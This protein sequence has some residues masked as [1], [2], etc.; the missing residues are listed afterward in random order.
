MVLVALGLFLVPLLL[1]IPS[2]A[3]KQGEVGVWRRAGLEGLPVTHLALGRGGE[4]PIFYA[5]VRHRGMY[6]S[7]DEGRTWQTANMDLPRG[8]WGQWAVT[9]LAVD[10]REARRVYVAL[11]GGHLFRSVNGGSRW[12]ALAAPPGLEDISLLKVLPQG[13]GLRWY[14]GGQGRLW[15]TD[16]EGNTWVSLG[17]WA[18]EAHL[19]DL[20]FLSPSGQDLC[21]AAGPEGVWCSADGGRSWSRQA[22]GLGRSAVWHLARAGDG[23]WY[24]GTHNGVYRSAD[25]GTFWQP[26]RVGLPGGIVQALCADPSRPATLYAG[27]AHGGV[28]RTEDGLHWEP[29]GLGLGSRDVFALHLDPADGNLLYAGTEDGLWAVR[30]GPPRAMATTTPTATPR[31]PT[32]TASPASTPSATPSA[33]PTPRPTATPTPTRGPTSTPTAT[34]SPTDTATATSTPTP[35]VA[36]PT[37]TA[38]ATATVQEPPT[39]TP[40]PRPPT[41]TPAPPTPTR[42]PTP[43]PK[44]PPTPTPPR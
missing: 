5:A 29:L 25:R 9:A 44:P 37:P 6:R 27:L 8:P 3:G 23:A 14:A 7:L 39:P 4:F 34:A 40:K 42:R 36:S 21:V 24:A 41:D 26:A 31:P 2:V 10:P 16:D 11:A 20:L 38:T 1:A 43:T 15:A 17:R 30:M 18:P 33:T 22:N 28:A 13:A 35:G 19:A 32:A 12:Q